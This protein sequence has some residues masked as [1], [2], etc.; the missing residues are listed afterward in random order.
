MI[1][2]AGRLLSWQDEAFLSRKSWQLGST[3]NVALTHLPGILH[4]MG[5]QNLGG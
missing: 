2:A 1:V 4:V 3:Y 5:R